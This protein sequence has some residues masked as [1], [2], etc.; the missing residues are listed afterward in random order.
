MLSIPDVNALT[1][2]TAAITDVPSFYTNGLT[3]V[4]MRCRSY[5]DQA[6][7]DNISRV[8]TV[9][10]VNALT[11]L[12]SGIMG[13]A[14]VAGGPVGIAGM[15]GSGLAGLINNSNQYAL[16]G[17]RPASIGTLVMT[18]QQTLIGTMPQPRTG[19][20]AYAR[21]YDAYAPC[22][23]AGIEA[24]Q[25]QAVAAAVNHLSVVGAP[26]PGRLSITPAYRSYQIR[27]N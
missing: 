17:T 22:S 27:V 1:A 7:L 13:I 10:Q 16:A 3:L 21:I 19:A 2:Q 26:A 4:Q 20:E 9:S 23:P 24:L 15:A 14:G 11:G 6:T 18:G 25:E 8:Q 5:F 12:A